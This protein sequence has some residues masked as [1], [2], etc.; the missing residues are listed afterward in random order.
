MWTTTTALHQGVAA[1]GTE[2]GDHDVQECSQDGARLHVV[3]RPHTTTS[4]ADVAGAQVSVR[5]TRAFEVCSQA[6]V[7]RSG[8]DSLTRR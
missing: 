3:I 5:Q 1:A 4:D 6:V 8:D 2:A 7:R